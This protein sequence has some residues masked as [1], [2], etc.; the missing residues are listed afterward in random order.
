[1]LE[2]KNFHCARVI[3]SGIEAMHTITKGQMKRSGKS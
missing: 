1:M 2:F 3:L